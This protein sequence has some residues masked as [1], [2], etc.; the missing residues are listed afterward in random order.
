MTDFGSSSFD[1]S[2]GV[3]KVGVDV[4]RTSVEPDDY[5]SY[6]CGWF[7]LPGVLP[8]LPPF[9]VPQTPATTSLADI[10]GV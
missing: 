2:P 7:C 1:I 8:H 4:I 5:R 6:K 9:E 10:A 3:T